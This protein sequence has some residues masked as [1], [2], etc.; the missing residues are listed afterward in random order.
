MK[1]LNLNT[2]GFAG[3]AQFDDPPTS[4]PNCF[5]CL[6]RRSIPGDAHSRCVHPTI[7]PQNSNE[8]DAMVDMLAGKTR[9]AAKALGIAGHPTGIARGWF[10]WPANSSAKDST[11]RC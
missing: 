9:D 10:M 7:G 8:F 6:H 5:K 2:G 1:R 11:C 4:K 3:R